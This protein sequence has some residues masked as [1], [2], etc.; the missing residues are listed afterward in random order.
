MDGIM[1]SGGEPV[2]MINGQIYKVGDL[3]QGREIVEILDDRIK[4]LYNRE[5][6]TIR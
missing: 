2:V 5:I 1:T 3:V 4:V 6:E